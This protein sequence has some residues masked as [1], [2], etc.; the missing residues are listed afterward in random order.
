MAITARERMIDTIKLKSD[1]PGVIGILPTHMAVA[2][3]HVLST[4]VLSQLKT[5]QPK[6]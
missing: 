6:W 1:H 3:H 2:A 4:A 5:M